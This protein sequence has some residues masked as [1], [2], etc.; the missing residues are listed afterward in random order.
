[1]D[2]EENRRSVLLPKPRRRSNFSSEN[3][4][5]RPYDYVDNYTDTGEDE[6]SPARKVK[7]R[8]HWDCAS[9]TPVPARWIAELHIY[10]HIIFFPPPAPPHWES[11]SCLFSWIQSHCPVCF[12]FYLYLGQ[13]CPRP[14][15]G[16]GLRSPWRR[17]FTITETT[18]TQGSQGG[19]FGWQHFK[20]FF[21]FLFQF[22][23]YFFLVSVPESRRERGVIDGDETPAGACTVLRG[24]GGSHV[25]PFSHSLKKK[26]I[27]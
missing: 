27:C 11:Q 8:R 14:G 9:W 24:S 16:G 13:F 5:R 26:K 23:F 19:R 20:I 15:I 17:G 25:A 3:Y 21:F 2:K 10:I 6:D 22:Y 18:Y 12:S 1:M 7:M 4:W